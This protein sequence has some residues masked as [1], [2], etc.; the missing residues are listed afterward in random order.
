MTASQKVEDH[1]TPAKAGV[2]K[3]LKSLDSCFRRNDNEGKN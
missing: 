2:H 1:V 3:E